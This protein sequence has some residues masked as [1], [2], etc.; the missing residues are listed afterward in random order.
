MTDTMYEEKSYRSRIP[1]FLTLLLVF[2]ALS[3]VTPTL[4]HGGGTP[5]LVKEPAGAYAMYVWT[6]PDPA[7]VGTFHISVALVQPDTDVPVLNA[8]VQVTASPQSGQPLT[9]AATHANAT[10]KTYYEADLQLAETGPLQVT[11]TYQDGDA[12]GSAGFET[13][14][15]QAGMNVQRIGLGVA[16][17]VIGGGILWMGR[18]KRAASAAPAAENQ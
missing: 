4:A 15:E 2:A 17:L 18:R 6:N 5:Q 14:V 16:L 3:P 8:A 12:S 10:V 7:R 11:V 13:Q 9:V 1:L